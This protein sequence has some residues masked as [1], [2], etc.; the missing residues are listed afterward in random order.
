M[1]VLSLPRMPIVP[2]LHCGIG[3]HVGFLRVRI[4]L[5]CYHDRALRRAHFSINTFPVGLQ[6][7]VSSSL[8][9]TPFN[10]ATKLDEQYKGAPLILVRSKSID[11]YVLTCRRNLWGEEYI[12]CLVGQQ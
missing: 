9:K 10:V 8:L 7:C 3:M 6:C 2:R 11:N 12:G 1:Y 4:V 5:P